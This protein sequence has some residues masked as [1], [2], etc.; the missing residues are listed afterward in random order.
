VNLLLLLLCLAVLLGLV[1]GLKLLPGWTGAV[2]PALAI[3]AGIV[4]LLQEPEGYD[5]KGF[6]LF[7]GLFAA[8]CSAVAWLLGRAA[9]V[10]VTW[11]LARRGS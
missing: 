10:A 6:G 3:V 2:W 5:M 4:L 8:W 1:S 7:M 9:F 11:V